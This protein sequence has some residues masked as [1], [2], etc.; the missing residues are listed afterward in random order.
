VCSTEIPS[1]VAPLPKSH[2]RRCPAEAAAFASKNHRN[3]FCGLTEDTKSTSQG[4]VS[5]AHNN[6]S[7]HPKVRA[8]SAADTG[9]IAEEDP[10]PLSS[11]T[12]LSTAEHSAQLGAILPST[13]THAHEQAVIK[14]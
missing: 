6:V 3:A 14:E 7:S 2:R 12:A 4:E 13:T 5:G 9:A 8:P 11:N 10:L 1:A